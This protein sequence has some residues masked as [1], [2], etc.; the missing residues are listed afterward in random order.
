MRLAISLSLVVCC[1]AA[2]PAEARLFWQ[3]Y[4][5]VV[6]AEGSFG[7]CGG[8]VRNLN[9]DY[10]VPRH[11]TSGRYMLYGPCKFSRST[12]PA[13]YQCHPL[14]PGYCTIYTPLRDCWRD[15]TYQHPCGCQPLCIKA[16][17]RC[18]GFCKLCQH[19]KD[20]FYG[21]CAWGATGS[22]LHGGC[23]SCLHGGCGSCHRDGCGLCHR[24][25][26]GSGVC[27]FGGCSAG[28]FAGPQF[29]GV[30]RPSSP[31]NM[32]DSGFEILGS[33]PVDSSELLASA[34]LSEMDDNTD[35]LVPITPSRVQPLIGLPA[36]GPTPS[37][38]ITQPSLPQP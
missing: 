12:S 25:G 38:E 11:C 27:G 31:P 5:S 20:D 23:R 10:F 18:G 16:G 21:A 37:G 1:L 24:G 4:G 22:C 29:Y 6:P 14:Y 8:C 28:G 7:G 13:S 9:Q 33:I 36:L 2:D 34:L 19:S 15:R 26:C 32:G 35:A 30:P 3:T 17:G